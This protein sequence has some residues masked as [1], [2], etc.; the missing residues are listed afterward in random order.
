[1]CV[2][3]HDTRTRM[4]AC[5]CTDTRVCTHSRTLTHTVTHAHTHTR[6]RIYTIFSEL[7]DSALDPWGWPFALRALFVC[8]LSAQRSSQDLSSRP[9]DVRWELRVLTAGLPGKSPPCISAEQAQLSHR[10]SAVISQEMLLN[11]A[12]ALF[13]SGYL[14]PSVLQRP[15][16]KCGCSFLSAS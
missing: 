13:K 9:G 15:T 12:Q 1:M 8:V 3:T 4:C 10:H 14:G 11:E 5:T 2:H 6:T 7:P 16:Q